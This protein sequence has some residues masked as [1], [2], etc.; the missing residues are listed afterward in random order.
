MSNISDYREWKGLF[1]RTCV[2]TRQ[3]VILLWSTKPVYKIAGSVTYRSGEYSTTEREIV[4][5]L[6]L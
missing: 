4:A 6:F 1:V 5:T 3:V 2:V